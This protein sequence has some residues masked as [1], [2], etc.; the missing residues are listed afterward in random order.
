MLLS[1]EKA[2]GCLFLFAGVL[3]LV[4]A[5]CSS[6][7]GP[8]LVDRPLV[9]DV[10]HSFAASMG[11]MEL[12]GRVVRLGGANQVG[13]PRRCWGSDNKR[14]AAQP[15]WGS[16]TKRPA[17]NRRVAVTPRAVVAGGG[18][19]RRAARSRPFR[20]GHARRR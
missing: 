14:S 12:C 9:G 15:E 4:V 17:P 7:G 8:R 1:S 3:V 20:S 6:A 10:G 16:D 13:R 5:G 2:A 18:P 19:G 11:G